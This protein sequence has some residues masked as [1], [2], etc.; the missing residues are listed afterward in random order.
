M[1]K[2]GDEDVLGQGGNP[3]FTGI[4]EAQ[5]RVV[6]LV[7][8]AGLLR[9]SVEAHRLSRALRIGD[10]VA[11]S[12]VCLTVTDIQG[13][14]F[15]VDVS[16]ETARRTKLGRL[17][18]RQQVNLELPLAADGSLGGHFV[19]GH[20]DGLGQ[21]LSSE[22]SGADR[23]LRI[24]HP[25]EN[26]RYV[27][28]KGSIAIDGV[29]LTITACQRGWFQVMLIPH[30]LTVTTLGELGPGD[31]VNLEYDILAKYM[32]RLMELYPRS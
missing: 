8:T 18:E 23:V 17:K 25:V 24:G 10:S 15:G 32:V 20:V 2:S 1:R 6:A 29:S 13:L 9:L 31:Y 3:L 27:V 14:R 19:Q 12:G 22:Q 26:D 5:G 4:V 7:E 16:N 21:I 28:E 11:V 30:T